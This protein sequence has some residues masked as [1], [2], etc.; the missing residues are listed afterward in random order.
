MEIGIDASRAFSP[1]PTGT[2]RYCH[3]LIRELARLDSQHHFILYVRAGTKPDPDMELPPNFSVREIGGDFLWTQLSLAW[4]LLRRPPE[5]LFVP[6]HTVP[7]LR[8]CPAIATVHGLEFRK[9]PDCYSWCERF[10]LEI[11][12]R[13]NISCAKKLIAPSENTRRDILEAYHVRPDKVRVVYHGVDKN[14]LSRK[15]HDGFNFLFIGRLEKRKNLVRLIRAFD[16]FKQGLEKV[17]AGEKITLT[18]AGKD[19]YG[20]EEIKRAITE[21]P[22]RDDIDAAGYVSETQKKESY[23]L[24]D[25]FV[26]PSLYEGFGLPV[27][28]AMSCGVPVICA[29]DSSLE[30]IA[31]GAAL[32]VDPRDE[33]DIAG[34]MDTVYHDKG[35]REEL[36]QRGYARIADRSWERCARETLSAI[37]NL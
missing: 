5:I 18:L 7:L 26:F 10:I 34:C 24:A 4:E 3:A 35:T 9:C 37:E 6:A 14:D 8:R 30:E 29:D 21:S 16:I 23:S 19:G 33:A 25:A 27:W 13:I 31:G 36:T 1:E 12:T 2:E 22:H 15:E 20:S 17:E 28:E 32:L 11:N